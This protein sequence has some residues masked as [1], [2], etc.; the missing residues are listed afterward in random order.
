MVELQEIFEV[1]YGSKLDLNKMTSLNPTVNF[2]GRSARNNGVTAYVDMLDTI[3]PYPKGMMTVAL[4]G[5]VLS[6][7]LQNKPFYTAQNVS[8]LKPKKAMTD[9]EKL[10]YC[11]V[12]NS[13]AYRY[14][15]CGREANRTLRQLPVPD[16]EE[17]PTWVSDANLDM[18]DGADK[19]LSNEE[20]DIPIIAKMKHLDEI[21]DIKNGIA[22]TNLTEFK[23][24][25]PNSVAYIRPAKTQRRT[26]RGYINKDSV[27]KKYIFP[28]HTL[29]VSTNGEGSHTYSYVS[30]CQ[31]VANSDVAV[32][33]PKQTNMPLEVKLYYAKCITANRYLFSYGRKP[34]GD[35]L[36]KIKIPYF[37][38]ND[39]E[40]IKKF[41]Q[42]LP[43]SH[44]LY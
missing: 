2:V 42:S 19:P 40:N 4:G 7:F 10:F 30:S 6:S 22:A 14:S 33:I 37:P 29:F 17:I 35:K 3:S 43:F 38:E 21:F 13:N 44:S 24:Y 16:L 8:V 9:Q 11:I 23:T 27:D 26:L 39:F 18:F 12:I 41:I 15:A 34:K 32:L 36:K 28:K 31:M 20:R 25:Q 5:S 1:T